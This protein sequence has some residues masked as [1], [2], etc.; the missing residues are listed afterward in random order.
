MKILTCPH[1]KK[2]ID[3]A[4]VTLACDRCGQ[5]SP[6]L[7]DVTYKL[8][9]SMQVRTLNL[10]SPCLQKIHAATEKDK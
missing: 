2:V 1:C 8:A 7:Y 3:Q 9:P 6:V 10:C 5:T 4:T